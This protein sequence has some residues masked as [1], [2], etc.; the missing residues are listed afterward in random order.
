MSTRRTWPS[1]SAGAWVRWDKVRFV[2]SGSEASHLGL[3]LARAATG[4]SNILMARF[5]YHGM[6]PEFESGS[7]NQ[8]GPS[9]FV[10]DFND[11]EAFEAI[12]AQHG[13]EIAGVFV[14]PML[15]AGGVLVGDKAFFDRIAMATRAAGALFVLDEVQTFR[16]AP[17]GLQGLLGLEPDLTLFG[18][19]I[20]GGLPAG[21]VGGKDAVMDL[22]DPEDLRVYHSGTYNGNPASMAAGAITVRDLTQAKIDHIAAL[23]VRLKAGLLVGAEKAGVPLTVNLTGSLMNT[24]FMPAAPKS[25]FGRTDSDFSQR[26]HIAALNHGVFF[27]PRGFLVISTNMTEALIDEVIEGCAA[28]MKDVVAEIGVPAAELA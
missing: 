23:G 21:A 17:G 8:P 27:A 10:A 9:T 28:A 11:A 13:H 3:K 12:L 18:K 25:A 6:V 20:G 4:R 24:F 26:F 14:E 1:R 2:N 7:M 15:G 16:L 19:F 22:F 5:G